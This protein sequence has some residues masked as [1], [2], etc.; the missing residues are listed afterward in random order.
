MKPPVA[1]FR[2]TGKLPDEPSGIPER[3]SGDEGEQLTYEAAYPSA[4]ALVAAIRSAG[5]NCTH[6]MAGEGGWGF[7]FDVADA[8]VCLFINWTGIEYPPHNYIALQWRVRRS[9]LDWVLRRHPTTEVVDQ[10][11][12]VLH[13]ALKVIPQVT[14]LHWLSDDELAAAYSRDCLHDSMPN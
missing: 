10:A 1:V 5:Y 7:D 13:L 3:V 4:D 8:T 6:P 9:L 11:R 14:D 12:Q 2:W